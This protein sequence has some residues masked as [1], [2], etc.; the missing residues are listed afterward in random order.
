TP[1]RSRNVGDCISDQLTPFQWRI[2]PPAPTA[3]TSLVALPQTPK[4]SFVVPIGI[5]THLL[6]AS[7][8]ASLPASVPLSAPPSVP[9]SKPASTP[10][11]P[12]ASSAI[13]VPPSTRL[14]K[15]TPR[16][17]LSCQPSSFR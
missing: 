17:R 2:V 15:Q 5:F 12:P 7:T 8:P 11:S 16:P 13:S 14:K 1:Y 3:Q 9:A 6:P 4:R 10:A